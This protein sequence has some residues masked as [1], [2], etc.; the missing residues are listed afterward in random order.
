[1]K[2]C[3]EK[4]YKLFISYSLASYS[5]SPVFNIESLYKCCKYCKDNKKCV[6]RYI[7]VDITGSIHFPCLE[8]KLDCDMEIS[9]KE[10]IVEIL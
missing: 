7:S 1:M 4:C 5:L 8:D 6:G 9:K 3:K 2:Y 10:L